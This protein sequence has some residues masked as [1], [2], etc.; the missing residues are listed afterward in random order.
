MLILIIIWLLALGVGGAH[1]GHT[2]G[3]FGGVLA[4]G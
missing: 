1:Y 2:R 3:G 4:S